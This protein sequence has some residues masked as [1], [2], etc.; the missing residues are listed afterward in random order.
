MATSVRKAVHRPKKALAPSKKRK[1]AFIWLIRH[2]QAEGN[3]HHMLNGNGIDAPLT[4]EGKRQAKELARHF[5]FK[6]DVLLS[7]PLTRAVSTARELAR[8]WKMQLHL[9]KLAEEQDY[10]E[11]TGHTIDSLYTQR[12][13]HSY[14]HIGKDI[15]QIYTLKCPH[16]ESWP[17]LKKR[18]AR[19][20]SSLDRQYAGQRVVVVSHSDFINCAYGVRFGLSDEEI[21]H[22]KDLLNCG[23]VR[24]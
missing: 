13:Y 1:S 4:R 18:A 21:F 2:G 5:P 8:K 14:F 10:G 12:R 11:F 15:N 16:G 9:T 22:R 20:L 6:P 19:F 24:L 3:G 17:Q 23:W 7:S